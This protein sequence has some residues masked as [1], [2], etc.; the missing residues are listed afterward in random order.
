[1]GHIISSNLKFE[2][3]GAGVLIA[4]YSIRTAY[5]QG[6]IRFDMLAPA[7]PY[8]MDW[9]DATIEI[10]DWAIPLSIAGK[11]Y[12]HAW[13]GAGREWIK[14]AAKGLP[15]WLAGM[16]ATIYCRIARPPLT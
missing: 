2:K 13:L 1:V 9:A 10:N 3:Q 7:D 8:K 16:L 5:E 15:P 12:A 11:L 4:D 6:C 14:V